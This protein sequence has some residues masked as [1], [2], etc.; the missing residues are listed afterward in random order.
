MRADPSSP[1]IEQL[2]GTPLRGLRRRLAEGA[3][4]LNL[5]PLAYQLLDDLSVIVMITDYARLLPRG[6]RN[7]LRVGL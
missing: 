7:D 1:T 3:S 2:T 6:G 4:P 5:D